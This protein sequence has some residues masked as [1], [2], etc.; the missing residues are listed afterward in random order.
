MDNIT[1]LD[2]NFDFNELNLANPLPLTGGS[3]FTKL[4]K[5]NLHKNFYL[6]L[7]KCLTKQGII[8]N[9]TKNLYRFNV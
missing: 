1:R 8:K 5:S 7:P 3:Y 6:Q 4:T 2:S 9:N